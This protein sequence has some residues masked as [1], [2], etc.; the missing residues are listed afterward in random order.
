MLFFDRKDH[1]L[2]LLSFCWTMAPSS[3]SFPLSITVA[4]AV[5]V[6]AA[7]A[8]VQLVP[9]QRSVTSS[10]ETGKSKQSIRQTQHNLPHLSEI[11][12]YQKLV[13][14]VIGDSKS[15]L[16]PGNHSQQFFYYNTGPNGT[17]IIALTD[18]ESVG[19]RHRHG[20]NTG[21]EGLQGSSVAGSGQQDQPTLTQQGLRVEVLWILNVFRVQ[22]VGFKINITYPILNGLSMCSSKLQ[23]CWSNASHLWVLH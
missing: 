20:S 8:A 21:K 9:I 4:L 23:L 13:L 16:F 11:S 19:R 18:Q 6:I 10:F 14:L 2:L 7:R 3:L 12:F 22:Y 5:F 15:H 1:C 17:Q